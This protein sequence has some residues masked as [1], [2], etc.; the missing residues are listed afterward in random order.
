MQWSVKDE[1][2][3]ACL[4]CMKGSRPCC[5]WDG[6]QQKIVVLPLVLQARDSDNPTDKGYW[7]LPKG[8]AARSKKDLPAL[9]QNAQ[10]KADAAESGGAE[11]GADGIVAE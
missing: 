3:Y 7:I 10:G 11:N 2:M 1:T 4:R 9:F 6:A 5:V 8:K